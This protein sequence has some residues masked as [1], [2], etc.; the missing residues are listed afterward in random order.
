[1]FTIAAAP[2]LTRT[3]AEQSVGVYLRACKLQHN[4]AMRTTVTAST[5]SFFLFQLMEQEG[6]GCTYQSPHLP[7]LALL[8]QTFLTLYRSET[9]PCLVS[10]KKTKSR[11][12]HAQR[13]DEL[14]CAF[15]CGL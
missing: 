10:F 3:P 6:K 4:V 7:S 13:T 2:L 1:M 5:T 8:H 9:Q 14:Q 12:R 11:T 15:L